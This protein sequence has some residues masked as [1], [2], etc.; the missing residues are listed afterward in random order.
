MKPILTSLFQHAGH[1]NRANNLHG[2]IDGEL[3][4]LK[5]LAQ[6]VVSTVHNTRV[7]LVKQLVFDDVILNMMNDLK[8]EK[9][10]TSSMVL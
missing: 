4:H 10:K 7:G 2:F 3:I 9:Q 1:E 6:F 5:H 8:K